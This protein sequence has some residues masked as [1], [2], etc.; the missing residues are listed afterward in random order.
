MEAAID[1]LVDSKSTVR[2]GRFAWGVLAYNL[3]VI[4]WGAYVRASGS[5][6]GCGRHWPL[7][8]GELVPRAESAKT[9]VEASHR[10]SAGLAMIVVVALM[11][12]TLR[13]V[14]RGHRA[15]RASIFSAVFIS[16][17]AL[18]GAGLVL[19]EL[20]A[21][22]E[23]MKRGLSMVLHLGNTFLLLGALTITAWTLGRGATPVEES[24]P[25]PAPPASPLVRGGV[26]LALAAVIVLGCSGAI[27]ALGDT[28]FPATSLRAGLAMDLSPLAHVFLRLR[29][30]HP[31]LALA[32]G[33]IV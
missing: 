26:F 14:P 19:F 12:W 5:G 30:L 10:V 33:A 9:L 23:S 27:A 18:I 21:K 3:L 28:L 8:N 6:A 15:R 13:T 11:I 32:T 22:D 4:A 7:C 20:V 16:G 25:T 24:A 31:F 2:L 1:T 17:E 29:V